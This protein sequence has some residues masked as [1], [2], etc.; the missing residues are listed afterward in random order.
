MIFTRTEENEVHSIQAI[1]AKIARVSM[2]DKTI[3]AFL[4]KA[5]WHTLII[6]GPMLQPHSSVLLS[7]LS[8]NGSICV[9]RDCRPRPITQHVP[10]T[11]PGHLSLTKL[12]L[13]SMY[14]I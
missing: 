13:N 8:D 2:P 10:K 1:S 3:D 12:P 4:H 11:I 7:A 6:Y 9:I 5:F 14:V